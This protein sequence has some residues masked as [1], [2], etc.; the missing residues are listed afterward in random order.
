M[1]HVKTAEEVKGEK[2]SEAALHEAVDA[3]EKVGAVNSTEEHLV[4]ATIA[5][6]WATIALTH[7]LHELVNRGTN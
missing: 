3:L 1:A 6:A 7:K 2:M 5:N 4:Q